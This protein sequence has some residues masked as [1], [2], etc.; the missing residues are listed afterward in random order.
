MTPSAWRARLPRFLERYLWFFENAIRDGAAEFGRSMGKGAMVLD[1]GAGEGQ[2]RE[3]FD[4][5]RYVGADLAIGD[6]NWNYA[7]LDVLCDL[8]RLPFPDGTFDGCLNIVTLEHVREPQAVIGE[9]GRTLK[10]GGR[11]FLVVPQDWEVH[12][13]PHDYFRYTRY[14]VRHLLERAG[15]EE[16]RLEPGGGYFRL[17]GRRL[18]NGIGL[19]RGLWLV[20]AVLL[21][22]PAGLLFPLLD[23]MDREKN[24]TL[25]YLCWARKR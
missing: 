4:H 5:C 6:A 15:F 20:P 18:L 23:G 22:A 11:L 16:I 12:Q 17:M 7:G 1:A 21:L 24:F 19:F 8:T 3:Y 13:A 9:L 14:G 10:R 2:Y 25:G